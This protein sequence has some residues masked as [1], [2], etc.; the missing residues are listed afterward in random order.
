MSDLKLFRTN[1]D[2]V[3]EIPSKSVELEKSLQTLIEVNLEVML[4]IQFRR[5]SDLSCAPA[6]SSSISS[7]TPRLQLLLAPLLK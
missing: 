5:G 6:R 1:S 4:G 3:S 7:E 2:K